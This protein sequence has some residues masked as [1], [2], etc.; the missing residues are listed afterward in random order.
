MSARA[1]MQDK[2][3][4][5][6]QIITQKISYLL[7]PSDSIFVLAADDFAADGARYQNSGRFLQH[8][9]S[10][11]LSQYGSKTVLQQGYFRQDLATD[12]AAVYGCNVLMK[13][14]IE[15]IYDR[16]EDPK[17]VTI[18]VDT[19]SARNKELLNSALLR[20]QAPSLSRV[21]AADGTGLADELMACYVHLLYSRIY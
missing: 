19:Y 9:L 20:M 2:L 14:S 17:E 7:T 11:K 1:Q 8:V 21:F 15:K 6:T 16:A 10:E 3:P 5:G 18:R 4:A 12:E 13:A